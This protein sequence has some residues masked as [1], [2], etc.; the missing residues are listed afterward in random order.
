MR[1]VVI[2]AGIFG[3]SVAYHLT[4]AGAE[5][6][7]VDAQREGRATEAGAGII[8]PWSSANTDPAHYAISAGGARYYP[9][10][11]AMLAEDG[12]TALSY[13]RVGGL[14]LGIGAHTLDRIE[15]LATARRA[16]APEAGAITRLSPAEARALFPPLHPQTAALHIEGGARMDG[17]KMAA[18]LRRAAMARGAV[19]Q[20]TGVTGLVR[21]GSRVAGVE[22]TAGRID[23][24]EVVL[25]AGAWAP[26]L[27]APL[28]ITLPVAPQR[29]QIL[30]LRLDG[31]DT[32][33]WPVVLPGTGHY[34][35][36]F[37]D[38]RV[39]VGATRETGSGFDYRLTAGGVMQELQHALAVAPGLAD[40]TLHELRI[41]MRPMS[42]DGR[43]LLGRIDGLDGLSVGNG[44]GP[45]G[46]TI[47][48]YAGAVLAALIQ[49]RQTALDLA[50]YAPL[51]G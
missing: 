46:L 38:S 24:D 16:T 7:M 9:E 37:D 42:A 20:E 28:G 39:V 21:A 26:A 8:C 36:S 47:G 34:L 15:A 25:T 44:L 4:R 31:Q 10:L 27:L 22:T 51:R 41:G 29:G 17:R 40:A 12:E 33:H 5:V 35:L 30:H 14:C 1:V 32:S 11:V 50:P 45:S 3:A 48:P 13:R 43:P 18:A 6:V 2:G 19:L 49:G 23:A